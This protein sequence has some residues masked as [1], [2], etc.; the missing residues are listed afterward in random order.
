MCRSGRRPFRS[1]GSVAPCTR[2]VLLALLF[3]A[4]PTISA[5]AGADLEILSVSPPPYTLA[6]RTTSI[7]V[8]FGEPIDPATVSTTTFRVFGQWSGNAVGTLTLSQN[9]HVLTFTP[10]ATFSS[11]EGVTINISRSLA[12]LSGATVRPEGYTF[13]FK[14]SVVPSSALFLGADYM[15]NR[16]DGAQTR[17]Y[18]ASAADLNNDGFCDLTSVNEVS[19]DVRVFLNT[20]DGT[21]VFGDFLEPQ[22][23]GQ[24]ASPN[25]PA[26]FD[27]DGNTDL[28]VSATS[29]ASV[30]V[31][32]GNGDGTFGSIVEIPVGGLPHG[33]VTLDVDGD[34][35]MD[36]V[37]ANAL[38][39]D[40]SLMINDGA[41]GFGAPTYFDG[42]VERE[43]GLAAADIDRDGVMDL[44]VGGFTGEEVRVLFG[45][46][47]GTFTQAASAYPSGGLTW[48]VIADDIDGDGNLD[49]GVANS[50]TGN[51]AVLYG[52]GDGSFDA[53]AIVQIGAHTPAVDFGDL[54]GDGD[55]DMVVSCFGGGF[56]RFY[57]NQGDRTFSSWTQINAPSNPSCAV[58]FDADND[59]DLDMAL[60]DEIADVIIIMR[61]GVLTDVD[62]SVSPPPVRGEV[63]NAPEPASRVTTLS[64]ELPVSGAVTLDLFDVS[65]RRLV[66]RDLGAFDS[67]SHRVRLDLDRNPALNEGVYVYRV[68][69]GAWSATDRV[70]VAR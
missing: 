33:I 48:V 44:V 6:E 30:W 35:D 18:G 21:G 50:T 39:D 5:S 23:I 55:A 10:A 3:G 51:V 64:F 45:N 19:A 42:G 17:I 54:D 8:E 24:E 34:A 56:W 4:L 22:G 59:Q 38:S 40:L 69:S 66:S 68:T 46:G 63:W 70:V 9:D 11:G 20:A 53:P 43:Y 7:V 57:E 13:Q 65:G 27:N 32:L 28:C 12:A 60:T 2:A 61:N 25:A 1:T 47:N 16:T 62:A 49:A 29:S 41:G 15:S 67:G 26:D 31:L 37:A 58:L 52:H 14:T 36:I